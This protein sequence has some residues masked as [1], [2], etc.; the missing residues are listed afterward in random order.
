MEKYPNQKFEKSWI[1]QD[2]SRE[3][4]EWAE[5]FGKYL[6]EAEVRK[7]ALT[8][9]Q[10]RKF[11]GEVKRIE[12]NPDNLKPNIV[13]L[14]PLLAYAVGRDK[15]TKIREFADEIGKGIDAI[16]DGKESDIRAN[17]NHF[18]KIF[19]AV[20]AYHKFYGNEK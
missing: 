17:Y 4:V 20:V 9:G 19:E 14:K 2:I 3:V 10:L 7:K 15:G 13:M 11:Y 1:S 18:V 16:L 6:S 12:T 5:S 8:T